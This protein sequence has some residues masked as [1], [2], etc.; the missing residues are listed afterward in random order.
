MKL[1]DL[2]LK[3]TQFAPRYDEAFADRQRPKFEQL[4]ARL[5][6]PMPNP[7]LDLGAGTGLAG[8]IL[9]VDFVM[10]D[11]SRAMLEFAEGR[12]VQGAFDALPFADDSFALIWAVTA[13]TEFTD[14][15]PVLGEMARVCRPG[16]YLALTLLKQDD[17]VTAEAVL[18]DLGFVLEERYDFGQE[19]GYIGRF[20]PSDVAGGGA[21]W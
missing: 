7:A 16:G 1:A 20:R 5:P 2:R 10:L 12:R 3:Y 4:A 9:G 11:A 8:R 19:F 18:T 21:L 6:S 15:V 17:V 14:P 13:L